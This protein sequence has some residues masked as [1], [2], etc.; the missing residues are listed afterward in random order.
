MFFIKRMHKYD[1]ICI[2]KKTVKGLMPT[3]YCLY[4]EE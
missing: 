3:G 2:C 4:I 1:F